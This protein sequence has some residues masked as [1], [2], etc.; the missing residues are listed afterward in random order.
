MRRTTL[1]ALVAVLALLGSGS[2]ALGQATA[3]GTIEGTVLDKSQSSISGAEVVITSKA[4]GATRNATTSDAGTFRFDLLPAGFY[5]TKVTKDGFGTV[6]ETVE[7][8]VGQTSTAN[9]TL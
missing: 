3:S 6:V 2:V 7:L 4:T 9:F 5:T 8:L 1:F